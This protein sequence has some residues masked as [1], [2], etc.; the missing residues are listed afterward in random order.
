M[1][2]LVEIE[3]SKGLVGLINND[4]A[5]CIAK[6]L[7]LN[8]YRV[9]L[10]ECSLVEAIDAHRV[11]MG[12]IPKAWACALRELLRTGT[13]VEGRDWKASLSKMIRDNQIE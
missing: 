2:T 6:V 9:V 3:L 8:T 4:Q 12:Y 1:E 13:P 10:D 11:S 7:K 5:R